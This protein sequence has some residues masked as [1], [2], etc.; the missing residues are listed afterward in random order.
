LVA[1]G[2]SLHLEVTERRKGGSAL[3]LELHGIPMQYQGKPHV[4]TIARDITQKKRDAAELQRQY[5]SL[6]QREKLA[7]LGSLLAGVSHE[8][9]NPLSVVVARAVLLE[10]QGDAATQS[11]ALKIR[12]AAERCARIVRTFLAMARQQR[13]ERGPVAMNDVISAALDITSYAVRTSGIDVTLDLAPDIPLI[14]ADAD[15]LHQV[16]LNLII[17]AQQ[18]LQEQPLPRRIRIESRFARASDVLRV[19]IADNGPGVP[20]HLRA[21][22]FEPYFTTKPTGVGTGVG[23]AVSLGIV[24]AHGGTLT[25]DCAPEGGAVFTVELPVNAVTMAG[26]DVEAP[27]SVDASRRR[28]LVV[29]DEVEIRDALTEILAGARHRVVGRRIRSRS[30]RANGRRTL[31]CHHHRYPDARYRRPRPLPGDPAPVAASKPPRRLRDRR[32]AR[33]G[34]ARVRDAERASGDREAVSAE[35]GAPHRRRTGARRG[36]RASRMSKPVQGA[37][38]RRGNNRNKYDVPMKSSR[39]TPPVRLSMCARATTPRHLAR[40]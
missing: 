8:L 1:S 17:N 5:D 3:E 16:F 2:E 30:A 33:V 15:Q 4:L 19:S 32:H 28:I 12:T 39:R 24:E 26:I 21:R 20:A 13:P 6:H 35:R 31:R 7:A 40:R 18:S 23:L 38:N 25:V 10:E 27:A 14:L 9:N 37:Q 22:I 29:D 34:I 36:E 11:A